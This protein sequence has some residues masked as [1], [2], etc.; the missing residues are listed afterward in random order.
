M[1]TISFSILFSSVQLFFNSL[2]FA[3][4]QQLTAGENLKVAGD[5]AGHRRILTTLCEHLAWSASRPVALWRFLALR[6]CVRHHFRACGDH[7]VS[8]SL[9]GAILACSFTLCSIQGVF[10]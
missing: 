1:E 3:F 10:M 2:F 6:Y 4:V 8:G 9:M 7:W 5:S